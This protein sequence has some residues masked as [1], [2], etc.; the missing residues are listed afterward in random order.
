MLFL[1]LSLRGGLTPVNPTAS[2]PNQPAI[3]P[4]ADGRPDS[5]ASQSVL[6]P[7]SRIFNWAIVGHPLLHPIS[8][9]FFLERPRCA[10]APHLPL[11][12]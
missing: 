3:P 9:P 11:P 5:Q 1:S 10:A 8:S 4:R 7:V 6:R 12:C 2:Y